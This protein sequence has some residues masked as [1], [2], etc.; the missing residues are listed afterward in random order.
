LNDKAEVGYY[1]GKRVVYVQKTKSGF[2]VHILL[3]RPYGEE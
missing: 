3:Y 2:T 1:L